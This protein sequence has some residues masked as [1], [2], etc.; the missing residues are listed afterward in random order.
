M[1]QLSFFTENSNYLSNPRFEKIRHKNATLFCP[2]NESE[3]TGPHF[4]GEIKLFFPP[5]SKDNGY[6]CWRC[7]LSVLPPKGIILVPPH[8]SFSTQYVG[9][10]FSLTMSKQQLIPLPIS[11]IFLITCNLWDIQYFYV[12]KKRVSIALNTIFFSLL[13]HFFG[14]NWSTRNQRRNN[15]IFLPHFPPCHCCPLEA[16]PYKKGRRR[17]RPMTASRKLVSISFSCAL[18]WI[19]LFLFVLFTQ[20]RFH[21][22]GKLPPPT[23]Q[24]A[25]VT[26]LLRTHFGSPYWAT[27]KKEKRV[28]DAKKEKKED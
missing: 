23:L 20:G 2:H 3:P 11:L 5:Y 4:A 18:L 6:C 1:Y 10:I 14:W 27:K 15:K 21:L 7:C 13:I 8:I 12:S 9:G 26:W 17:G 22:L 25:W 16:P 28:I 24:T 19:F